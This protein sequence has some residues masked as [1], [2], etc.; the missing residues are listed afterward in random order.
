MNMLTSG[1]TGLCLGIVLSIASMVLLGSC[2]KPVKGRA[3]DPALPTFP[4]VEGDSLN[5]RTFRIPTDL[6]APFNILIVAFYQEQ[7]ADVDTWLPTTKEIVADHSN[8][9]Y[10][11]LPTISQRFGLVQS[12]VDNGMRSGIPDFCNRERTIT[13]YTDTEKFR[14]LAGIEDPKRIWIGIVDRQGRVY[15][16][17][18]DVATPESLAELRK[19]VREIAS[20]NAP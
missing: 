11:E 5:K 15:W 16:S 14:E 6:D 19:V 1:F 2:G 10:Y 12:W 7:Q 13:L 4:E 17:T 9:E 20:P 3:F 8:V 18:R